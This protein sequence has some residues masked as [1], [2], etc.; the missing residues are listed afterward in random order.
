MNYYDNEDK[1]IDDFQ[2]PFHDVVFFPQSKATVRAYKS[3]HTKKRWKTW[4]NSA[5]KDAPPPDYYSDALGMM[6]EIMR[7]DDHTHV[8]SNGKL[9]N[10]T[11]IR[12][13]KLQKEIRQKLIEGNPEADFSN[14]DIIVNAVT[15]LPTNEDHNY[16]FYSDSFERVLKKHI[17]H[18]PLYRKNHP[19]KKLIFFVFDESSAYNMV[20]DKTLALRGPVLGECFLS[21]P[22]KHC[23]DRKFI[24]IFKDADIDFLI[25]FSPFKAYYLPDP[26]QLLP[27]VAVFDVKNYKFD[28]CISYPKNKMVSSET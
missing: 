14:V 16:Q 6:M 20:E 10:P 9:I 15:D 4:V 11:N 1:V 25:W 28:A 3:I 5:A 8:Q 24:E 13:S 27:S 22:H 23:L 7:V 2:M 17:E 19:N 26:T 18:I 21:D 12:E